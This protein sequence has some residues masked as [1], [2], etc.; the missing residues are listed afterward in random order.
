MN[1]FQPNKNL[2]GLPDQG[3]SFPELKK[4][5]GDGRDKEAIAALS[6][7]WITEGVPWLFLG[8]AAIY[9]EMRQWLGECLKVSPKLINMTGSARTGFSMNPKKEWF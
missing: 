9:E 7:L 1:S 6:R 2:V 8:H 3:I 5:I 4:A